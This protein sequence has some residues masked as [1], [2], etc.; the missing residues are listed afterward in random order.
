MKLSRIKNMCQATKT[1]IVYTRR[2]GKQFISNGTGIWSTDDS[3]WLNEQAVR[4]IMEISLEK[5]D[6]WIYRDVNYG[7]P[8]TCAG[9]LQ[10]EMLDDIWETGTE[11]QL[12]MTTDV[13][14]IGGTEIRRFD[15]QETDQMFWAPNKE[16]KTLGEDA[17]MF[18]LR[19]TPDGRRA[20]AGYDSIFCK[21][22]VLIGGE[23]VQTEIQRTLREL[24]EKRVY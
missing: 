14:M 22:L 12:I 21:G 6:E 3:L 5:W 9:E 13:I 17:R 23:G 8:E 19:E 1:A 7:M 16:L 20:V 11:K 15:L 4:C 2:D 10:D 18:A 24:G